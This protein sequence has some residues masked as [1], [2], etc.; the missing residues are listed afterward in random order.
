MK[1]KPAD[2][3]TAEQN[4]AVAKDKCTADAQALEEAEVSF[5]KYT[6][7]YKVRFV[8]TFV[9]AF[10]AIIS[11]RQKTISELESVAQA[12]KNGIELVHHFDDPVIANFEKRYADLENT[13][14]E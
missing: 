10:S 3:A 12:V 9:T 14:I 6:E 2:I 5:H 8:E 1:G 11:T 4:L 7:E 13:T